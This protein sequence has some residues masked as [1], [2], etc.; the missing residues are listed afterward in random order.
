MASPIPW[1][2]RNYDDYEI[3]TYRVFD[4]GSGFT[5]AEARLSLAEAP[6]RIGV[7]MT[8]LGPL[9]KGQSALLTLKVTNSKETVL[10]KPLNFADATSQ[11]VNPADR[12]TRLHRR[13]GID[14]TCR[15]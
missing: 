14:R 13:G 15:H 8:T 4:A 1:F 9:P 10:T 2:S 5:T 12:G 11:L 6:V 3:G 7:K